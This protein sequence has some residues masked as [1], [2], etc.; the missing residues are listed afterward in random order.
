MRS[1]F[2]RIV[3]GTAS[4]SLYK[5]SGGEK[6]LWRTQLA[7]SEPAFQIGVKT[8]ILAARARESKKGRESERERANKRESK[9]EREEEE[10]EEEVAAAEEE[11]D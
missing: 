7:A 8:E 4:A 3:M 6:S 1:I 5:D 11:E 9:R 2:G 10:E